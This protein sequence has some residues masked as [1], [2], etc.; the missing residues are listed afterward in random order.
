MSL[1]LSDSLW[2]MLWNIEQDS[3]I[4]RMLIYPDATTNKEGDFLT[5]RRGNLTYMPAGRTQ[6]LT[7]DGAWAREGRQEGKPARLVRKFIVPK[8][9][10][11]L[12]DKDFEIFANRLRAQ[13]ATAYGQFSVVEGK[14]ILFWYNGDNYKRGQGSLSSSCMR[15]S[16][17]QHYLQLYADHPNHIKMLCFIDPKDDL[18]LARGLVWHTDQGVILDRIYG[19][20]VSVEILRDYAAEQ[21]WFRRERNS[22]EYPTLFL[23]PQG[24]QKRICTNIPLDKIS[25]SMYPYVDTFKYLN[26]NKKF[27][28]NSSRRGHEITLNHAGGRFSYSGSRR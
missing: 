13:D 10:D 3:R 19:S 25:Y 5:V 23:D 11:A 20:D 15:Y 2:A 21:G 24:N 17:C 16:V 7:S 9:L 22:Y 18:L 12:N 6:C 26:F 1:I 4:A 28:T 8:Y 14:D 27:L